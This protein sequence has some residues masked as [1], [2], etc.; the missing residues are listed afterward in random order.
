MQHSIANQPRTSI[1]FLTRRIKK[2][3]QTLVRV[4]KKLNNLS[5]LR[6][7]VF[8]VFIGSSLSYY[9]TRTDNRYYLL[10]ILL[11]ATTFILLVFLYRK[12]N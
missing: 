4:K 5:L 2:I 3:S 8:S 1:Q 10:P 6:L 9:L 7:T 12:I 11:L